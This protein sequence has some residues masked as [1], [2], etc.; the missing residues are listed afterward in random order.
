VCL[1]P[2]KVRSLYSQIIGRGTRLAPGK[3]NCLVLDFLWLSTQHDLCRP[4]SLITANDEDAKKVSEKLVE[5]EMDIFEA[6][7][8]VVEE[9]RESLAAKLEVNRRKSAK[10]VDPLTFFVDI[11]EVAAMDYVPEF[12]WEKEQ[13]TTKQVAVIEN[14]GIDPTG[15][16]K[17]KASKV[18]D[19]IFRRRDE[20]LATPKQMRLLERYG[21]NGVALWTIEQSK[22]MI[23]RIA[24][25]RWNVPW[26]IDPK[27][28][29]PI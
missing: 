21:F 27:T 5:D 11:G 28:Y 19:A 7:R 18:I 3:R 17:G 1:R 8:D 26:D 16:C 24:R 22:A 20:G 29:R 12:A 23:D 9:R 25:N 6:E 14:A 2:T 15:M 13:P 10:L 4:A